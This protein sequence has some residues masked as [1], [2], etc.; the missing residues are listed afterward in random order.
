M[1]ADIS[2]RSAISERRTIIISCCLIALVT[3]AAQ[4]DTKIQAHFDYLE[5]HEHDDI[6]PTMEA[7]IELACDANYA[8]RKRKVQHYVYNTNILIIK[9]IDRIFHDNRCFIL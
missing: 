8:E 2:N 1:I 4:F 5:K 6:L 7:V 3:M 9:N